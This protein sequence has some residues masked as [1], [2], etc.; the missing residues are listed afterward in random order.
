MLLDFW[1]DRTPDWLMG[2]PISRMPGIDWL[3][4][5]PS[6]SRYTTTSKSKGGDKRTTCHKQQVMN[7]VVLG[8]TTQSFSVL[9]GI[10]ASGYGIARLNALIFL[11]RHPVHFVGK[12]SRL[13]LLVVFHHRRPRELTDQRLQVIYMTD[14]RRV[15][16]R[17]FFFFR[18][19]TK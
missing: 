3:L 1:I 14:G 9:L 2:S 7:S 10:H 8:Y 15:G 16:H 13:P 4:H 18:I 5:H 6:S 12:S 19:E 11:F 17:L